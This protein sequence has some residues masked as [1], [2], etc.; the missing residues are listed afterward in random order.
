MGS[1]WAGR[2]A[3]G[4][5]PPSPGGRK[6]TAASRHK[7]ADGSPVRT[8]SSGETGVVVHAAAGGGSARAGRAGP[9]TLG[10]PTYTGAAV[11]VSPPGWTG[12][13]GSCICA[14]ATAP[15]APSSHPSC[16]PPPLCGCG[17]CAR[18]VAAGGGPGNGV[19]VS[20]GALGLVAGSPRACRNGTGTG[21]V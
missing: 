9:T 7:W 1:G 8:S 4:P 21:P 18:V 15:T 6:R 5:A 11:A 13:S 17:L 12:A 3:A 20:L 14:R 10:S 19:D 2:G 16:A